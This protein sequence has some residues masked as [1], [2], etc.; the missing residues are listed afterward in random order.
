[1]EIHVTNGQNIIRVL[2][3]NFIS[4]LIIKKIKV[5]NWPDCAGSIGEYFS[6]SNYSENVKLE[7][8]TGLNKALESGDKTE[9]TKYLPDFLTLFE[10][11]KYEY[12]FNEI[13]LSDSYFHK[14]DDLIYSHDTPEEEKFFGHFY[15]FSGYDY[16][17]SIQSE[18]ISIERI[19]YYKELINNGA[20]PIVIIYNSEFYSQ[21]E[22][23]SNYVLD[24]HH[25][26]EAYLSLKKDIPALFI[27]K[28]ETNFSST[29]E[30]LEESYKILKKNEFE[31][32]FI[33]SDDN[34]LKI[35]FTNNSFLTSIIDEILINNIE[36]DVSIINLLIKYENSQ[37]QT[38]NLWAFYRIKALKKNKYLSIFNI[39][40]GLKVWTKRKHENY[41]YGWH[42]Q[43][44]RN[45][46]ELKTW[47]NNTLKK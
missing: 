43:I 28:I 18:N 5:V 22:Y 10:N 7:F 21:F 31:H 29:S 37:I 34:L 6:I 13:S 11:G 24:G 32:L 20:K 19:K 42:Q 27:G 3:D 16:F 44:L 8:S 45:K 46:F 2:Y 33:N 47:L 1:M 14:S 30:I 41:G 36:I 15:P 40:K 39:S 9:I 17:F 12:A 35:D 23:S 25:K 38:E 26:I 4:C